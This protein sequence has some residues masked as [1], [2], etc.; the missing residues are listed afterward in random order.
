M[1]VR[2]F[3]L[4]LIAPALA[5]WADE[6]PPWPLSGPRPD[7]AVPVRQ[8]SYAPINAGTKYFVPVEPMPWGDANRRVTPKQ[9]DAKSKPMGHDAH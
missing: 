2:V 5:G 4:A 8:Q 6:S 3:T 9:P 1:L 7:R